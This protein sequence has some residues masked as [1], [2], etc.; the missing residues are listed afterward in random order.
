VYC[1][2]CGSEISATTAFCSTCGQAISGVVPTIPSLSPVDPNQYAPIVPP[3]YGGVQYS[4]VAYAG[5]WL[6]LVA[7]LIDAAISFFLF[8][9]LLIPLFILTGAGSALSRIGSRED[10]SDDVAAFVGIG[11]VLGFLVMTVGVTWLYYALSESSSWQG[12]LG[13]KMLNLTVTDM[14]GQPISFGRASGRYFSKFI[15]NL[16][17]LAIGYILAGFTEKKQ[18]I[19]D[20]IASC[21]VLRS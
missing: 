15:T 14:A 2:K 17:P 13:K 10:I 5:F 16:I 6:R 8:L 4:G 18:A 11:F 3:S 21:L 7:F 12:T 1:S 20:M 19:H 9:I